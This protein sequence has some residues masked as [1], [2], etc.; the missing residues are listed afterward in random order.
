MNQQDNIRSNTRR[1]F[2]RTVVGS[3][4]ITGLASL[5][6]ASATAGGP[7]SSDFRAGKATDRIYQQSLR[8]RK[9][10][11]WDVHEWRSWLAG[12]GLDF[13]HTGDEVTVKKPTAHGG[14]SSQRLY[15]STA[16]LYMT[17]TRGQDTD[18][19]MVEWSLDDGWSSYAEPP[20]DYVSISFEGSY[21]NFTDGYDEDYGDY[22]DSAEGI[23]SLGHNYRVVSYNADGHAMNSVGRFGSWFD[24]KLYATGGS[25]QT[26]QIYMDYHCRWTEETI[27]GFVV[28]SNGDGG[29]NFGS[30]DGHWRAETFTSEA[31]MDNGETYVDDDPE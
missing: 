22:T 18:H 8:L 6:S 13:K 21:Y 27:T 23:D 31:E 9:N 4:G 2:L 11:G 28:D 19:L 25:P 10:R 1:D 7:D 24:T 14:P 30:E 16:R 3:A 20:E 17:Y 29:L 5:G 26:R 12:H 15:E